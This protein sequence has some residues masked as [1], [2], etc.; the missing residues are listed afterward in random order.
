MKKAMIIMVAGLCA[1]TAFGQK[2]KTAAPVAAPATVSTS[3]APLKI[4]SMGADTFHRA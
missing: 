2:K 1:A 4:V 3:S